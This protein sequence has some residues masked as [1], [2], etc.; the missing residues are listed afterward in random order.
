MCVG[1]SVG[2]ERL[3]WNMAFGGGDLKDLIA[4]NHGNEQ[5]GI[6]GRVAKATVVDALDKER[7]QQK[8]EMG[9]RGW[10]KS[11]TLTWPGVYDVHIKRPALGDGMEGN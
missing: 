1:Q 3:I 10:K 9:C 4:R 8:A 2:N 11:S 5:L 6:E 7:Q